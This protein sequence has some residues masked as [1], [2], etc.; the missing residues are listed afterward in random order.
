MKKVS[1]SFTK[2][3]EKKYNTFEVGEKVTPVNRYT[4]LGWGKV[5]TVK[6][7]IEP[8]QY[9][10][11]CIA[12]LDGGIRIRA[13][14]LKL[15]DQDTVLQNLSKDRQIRKLKNTLRTVLQMLGTVSSHNIKA[16]IEKVMTNTEVCSNTSGDEDPF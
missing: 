14:Q 3:L 12:I 9:A 5:Y 13:D 15:V 7:C 6:E 1:K 16:V 4:T 2:V 11:D 8:L 10:E